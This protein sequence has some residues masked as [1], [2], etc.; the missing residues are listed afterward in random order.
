ME[1]ILI[2]G[3]SGSLGNT[4]CGIFGENFHLHV[5]SRGENAQWKLRNKYPN[6]NCI[7]GD[8]ADEKRV[9]NTVMTI[10]PTYII[11]ASA[12]KHIDICEFNPGESI[13]T[14]I[15]GIK[16][17]LD[18]IIELNCDYI[19]SVVFVSTD[20]ACNPINMYGMCKAISEKL[21]INASLQ[22]NRLKY[23][24]F[25]VVRYGNVL[26]SNG[27]IIPKFHEI[28]NDPD[29]DFFTVTHQEMTRFFMT[30]EEGVNI[31]KYAM[32]KGENGCI[33]VPQVKSYKIMDIANIFTKIYKKPICITE[34]RP[35]EKMHEELIN[36]DELLN[37]ELVDSY[38]K[39]NP[40][41]RKCSGKVPITEYTSKNT[42][43][44]DIND[45]KLGKY[46]FSRKTK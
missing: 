11:I 21:V 3:G 14:N 43:H 5:Y 35:G 22:K 25:T 1:S 30:L 10:K 16:T 6:V 23:P 15:L 29:K 20:K 31:I 18:S 8:I 38:Y 28:G 17:I 45:E 32:F 37:T 42:S 44:V 4:L 39:I 40:Y 12:L 7:I 13:K 34:P 2:F 27:S 24:R 36:K 9:K 26:D 46:F 19:K 33:Y 41:N